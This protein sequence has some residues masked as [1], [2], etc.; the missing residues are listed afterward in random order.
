MLQSTDGRRMS[1]G[2]TAVLL[3]RHYRFRLTGD[4]LLPVAAGSDPHPSSVTNF[5][6]LRQ[7][8]TKT[9]SKP[10]KLTDETSC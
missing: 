5:N 7:K 9:T 4:R 6:P 2:K 3:L 1:I 10:L 8:K